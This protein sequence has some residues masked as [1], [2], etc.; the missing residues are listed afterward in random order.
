[1]I[2]ASTAVRSFTRK[3]HDLADRCGLAL[4]RWRNEARNRHALTV[5]NERVLRDIGLSRAEVT[6][7]TVKRRL[8]RHDS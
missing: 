8:I 4:A 5:M 1:M 2:A 6:A 7:R 3:L